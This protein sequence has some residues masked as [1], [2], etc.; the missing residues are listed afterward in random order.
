LNFKKNNLNIISG[1]QTGVERAA[2]DF[3]LCNGL[4]CSGWCQKGR[5]DENGLI[6]YRYPL[7]EVFSGDVIGLV[8]QNIIESEGVLIIILDEMDPVTQLAYDLAADHQK[9][10]FV[11]N[12]SKNRNFRLVQQWIAKENIGVLNITGP[13]EKTA[14]GI[15]EETLDV[16]GHIFPDLLH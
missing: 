11:W 14:P 10:V 2:L 13:N 3:A 16:L 12:L 8:L 6:P 7:Y 5:Q 1:G 9:P 4:S 15:H